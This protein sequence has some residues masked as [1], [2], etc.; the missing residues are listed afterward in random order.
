MSG[1]TKLD[2]IPK[3]IR[4]LGNYLMSWAVAGIAGAGFS[5]LV[6][7]WATEESHIYQLD[8][9]D[10]GITQPALLF[11]DAKAEGSITFDPKGVQDIRVCDYRL[12]RGESPWDMTMQYLEKYDMCFIT[13][14][15]GEKMIAVS[16]NIHSGFLFE[17]NDVYY[18]KCS[19]SAIQ[20]DQERENS[21]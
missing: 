8:V 9:D 10:L 17:E 16:P 6:A 15:T 11:E 19:Q 1:S 18:C 21:R 13:N 7:L 20:K 2:I 14:E 4:T 12:I 3:P 5:L